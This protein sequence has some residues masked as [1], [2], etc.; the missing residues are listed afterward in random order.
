MT[1]HLAPYEQQIAESDEFIAQALGSASVPA[2]MIA[3][4]HMGGDASD[5]YDEKF[6]AAAERTVWE[7]K[8]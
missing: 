4:V 5:V 2:L 7:Y 1:D 3:M 6:S 8:C